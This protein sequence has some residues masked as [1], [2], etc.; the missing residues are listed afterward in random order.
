[1]V[2]HFLLETAALSIPEFRDDFQMGVSASVA[3]G[4]RPTGADGGIARCS[5][6]STRCPLVRF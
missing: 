1:M 6:E 3:T 2:E 4:F 5:L